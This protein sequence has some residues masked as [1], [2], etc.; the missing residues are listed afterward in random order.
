MKSY[1]NKFGLGLILLLLTAFNLKAQEEEQEKPSLILDL[2]YFN[3][4]N[5]PPYLVIN[6][7]AKVDGKFQPV[8]NTVVKLY[9]DS[10]TGENN[11]LGKYI[12]DD[13]GLA[14]AALPANIQPAWMGSETHSFIA[15]AEATKEFGEAEAT[16]D[17]RKSKITLDT[18][19]DGETRYIVVSVTALTDGQ[20]VPLK[21]VELKVGIQRLGGVLPVNDK[22][23]FTTD[24]AGQAMAE[25]ARLKLPGDEKGNLTIVAQV[26][27]NEMIGNVSATLSTPWGVAAVHE[28]NFFK[29]TL[30]GTNHRT[31]IWLLVIAY[32]I[33]GTVWAVLIFL[34]FQLVRIKKLGK[35]DAD[36]K[37]GPGKVTGVG[38]KSQEL[39]KDGQLADLSQ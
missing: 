27:D 20:W 6:S 33:I 21:D 31:P 11:L 35:K 4:A 7:R 36:N 8:K 19:N 15:L 16:I 2:R 14:K 32:S 39:I 29:R 17:V 23:S 22:E 10:T 25:F 9:I 18:S 1:L 24:S 34:V 5:T 38:K 13:Q 3:K 37:K 26:E 12:T 28:T 30:W